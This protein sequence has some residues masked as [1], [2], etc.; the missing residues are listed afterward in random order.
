[1]L[2]RQWGNAL[3]F[4]GIKCSF[5]HTLLSPQTQHFVLLGYTYRPVGAL[6]RPMIGHSQPRG[7]AQLPLPLYQSLHLPSS[8]EETQLPSNQRGGQTLSSLPRNGHSHLWGRSNFSPL[9]QWVYHPGSRFSVA[10]K[11]QEYME[12]TFEFILELLSPTF[13]FPA[14]PSCC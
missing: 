12:L 11:V 1:M 14:T 5:R 6:G 10:N 3:H 4:V 7:E 13:P 2:A 9:Y 8:L